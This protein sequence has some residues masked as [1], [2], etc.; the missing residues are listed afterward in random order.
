MR[1]NI[2]QRREHH[3]KGGFGHFVQ[4]N[5]LTEDSVRRELPLYA[6]IEIHREQIRNPGDPRIGRFRRDDVVHL[7]RVGEMD[8]T[9]LQDP[10]SP[11]ILKG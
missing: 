3:L 8:A 10:A 2:V 4:L 6:L 5:P 1:K 7:V 11:P 9:I